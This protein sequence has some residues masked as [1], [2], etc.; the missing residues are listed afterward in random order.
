MAKKKNQRASAQR[1]AQKRAQRKQR[2]KTKSPSTYDAAQEVS[3]DF[4]PHAARMDSERTLRGL[5]KLLE[6]QEFA[7]E[8]EMQAFLNTQIVGGQL[9][10]FAPETPEEEAQELMYDAWETND[11]RQ[12]VAMARDALTIDPNCVDAYVLLAED[13]ASSAAEAK[14]FYAKAVQAGEAT[15]GPEYFAENVGHF[16][17][18]TETRPYMRARMGLADCY[19]ALGEHAEAIAH[20]QELLRLNP[21]DNQGV[22]YL[23]LTCLLEAGEDERAE[24]LL[25][26]FDDDAF[27][28]WRYGRA[29]LA[30]RQHESSVTADEALADAIEG[31]KFVPDYLLGK[32]KLPRRPPEYMGWGDENEAVDYVMRSGH[33]WQQTPGALAWLR[34]YLA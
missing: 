22:R 20:Y 14:E 31:N 34:E 3:P 23:L 24:A 32:R 30:F 5:N 33:L 12:R 8:E 16:W 28:T 26:Q 11:V 6:S 10:S 9:P 25:A 17:G 7:S 1:R 2:S 13:A 4:N 21:G 27:A 18:I 19:W 29:L 15:F